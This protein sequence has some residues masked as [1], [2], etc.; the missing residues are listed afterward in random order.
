[1]FSSNQEHCLDL[2]QTKCNITVY[3]CQ[4]SFFPSFS[5]SL[6]LT[7]NIIRNYNPYQT[8]FR[9]RLTAY[10]LPYGGLSLNSP[11][12]LTVCWALAC[13]FE[14]VERLLICVKRLLS[15]Y[16]RNGSTF[17]T[18]EKHREKQQTRKESLLKSQKYYFSSISL[19]KKSTY[20]RIGL[21]SNA[22]PPM[23]QAFS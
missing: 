21:Y 8:A 1:M 14:K 13:R 7:S 16:Y 10:P 20:T 5:F 17:S 22:Y 12:P 9:L 11:S 19:L 23:W 2:R 4:V 6:N 15:G 3:F 18:V